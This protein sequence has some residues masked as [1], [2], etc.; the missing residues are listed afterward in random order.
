MI[1]LLLLV[2]LFVFPAGAARNYGPGQSGID[3]ALVIA[4]NEG[5]NSNHSS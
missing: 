3:G 2:I 5:K 4:L 1:L